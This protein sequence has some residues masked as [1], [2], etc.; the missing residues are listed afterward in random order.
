MLKLLRFR[1]AALLAL[2]ISAFST[3][4]AQVRPVPVPPPV[5][6]PPVA[7]ALPPMSVDSSYV[8]GAGDTVEIGLVGRSDFAQRSR[9]SSEG[10]ILLP[11]IGSIH[12]AD[13]TVL[14][15]A[16]DIR[17][18]LIKGGFYSDPIVRAEVVVISSRYAT[19]LGN[20]GTPGLLPLDRNYHLSEVLAKVG[21]RTAAGADYLLLTRATGGAPERYYISHLGSG[22]P[23]QDP[24]VKS[25]DKI[26]IPS[27]DAEVFYL[28]GQV[29]TPG[30][31]PVTEGLTVR[32][33][34]AKGGGVNENGSENKVTIIRDGK[35]LKGVK[36][37]DAVKVGDVIKVGE[38]LF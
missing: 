32:T 14:D 37:E 23:D 26:F 9:I 20:V 7:S 33:A 38:R 2:S 6:A 18:A 22:G 4:Q 24:V 5:S 3:A 10:T 19:I 25:G 31:Y 36:L 16:D 30:N 17:K 1:V 27:A 35:P 13:R 29:N 15:L 28:S 11:L 21:G 8:L 12:A 34:I